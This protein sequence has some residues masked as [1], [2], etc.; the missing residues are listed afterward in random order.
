M[1]GS[2]RIALRILTVSTLSTAKSTLVMLPLQPAILRSSPSIELPHPSTIT[3]SSF[4]M[5][6][7][8][9]PSFFCLMKKSESASDHWYRISSPTDISAHSRYRPRVSMYTLSQ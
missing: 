7:S 2:P 8:S 1:S 6:S 5:C 9:A 4:P 3:L